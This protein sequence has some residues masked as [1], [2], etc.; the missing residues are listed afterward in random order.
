MNDLVIPRGVLLLDWGDENFVAIVLDA[1]ID[2]ILK[3][4]VEKGLFGLLSAAARDNLPRFVEVLLILI[5]RQLNRRGTLGLLDRFVA[6][7]LVVCL[8]LGRHL[9]N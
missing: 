1:G 6:F 9:G 7:W 4:L 8:S 2:D 5:I 3:D